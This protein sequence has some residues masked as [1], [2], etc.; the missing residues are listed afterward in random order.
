M[1]YTLYMAVRDCDWDKLWYLSINVLLKTDLGCNWKKIFK[2]FELY[3][4]LQVASFLLPGIVTI[5]VSMYQT[6]TGA[7]VG[8]TAG[9]QQHIQ[10]A[11]TPISAAGAT[12]ANINDIV[13]VAGQ[14][15]D[16]TMDQ[17]SSG[18]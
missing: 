11:M 1:N 3:L 6:I 13:K 14:S 12:L 9:D 7:T 18:S 17:N 2:T 15:A 16:V 10:V 4:K 5:P 8:M